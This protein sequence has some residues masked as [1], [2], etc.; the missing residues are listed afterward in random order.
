[1]KAFQTAPV[2]A[3]AA[4]TPSRHDMDDAA[5]ILLGLLGVGVAAVYMILMYQDRVAIQ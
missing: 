5:L 1:M 3:A 4:V 2:P